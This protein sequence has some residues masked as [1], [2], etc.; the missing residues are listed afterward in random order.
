MRFFIFLLILW[1]Q[2]LPAW[3][4]FGP[5]T[6]K[7]RFPDFPVCNNRNYYA[8]NEEKCNQ[9]LL[10][11]FYGPQGPKIIQ[12]VQELR[13]KLRVILEKNDAAAFAELLDYPLLFGNVD[14]NSESNYRRYSLDTPEKVRRV[15]AY[16][17]P[18]HVREDFLSVT[19]TTANYEVWQY[20][21]IRIF[22][23]ECKIFIKIKTLPLKKGN[24]YPEVRLLIQK[25][26]TTSHDISNDTGKIRHELKRG[27]GGRNTRSAAQF[28]PR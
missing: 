23:S 12:Q 28:R 2:A 18:E 27:R 8:Y 3:G 14:W 13:D 25:I 19:N 15:F 1:G 16:I 4:A 20:D 17:F 5:Y 11:H 6:A 24:A 10:T 26:Q 7:T 21:M 9:A 22:E